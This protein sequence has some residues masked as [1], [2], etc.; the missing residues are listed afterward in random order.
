MDTPPRSHPTLNAIIQRSIPTSKGGTLEMH[1]RNDAGR[2]VL[3]RVPLQ[4][5]QRLYKAKVSPRCGM[6]GI[7]KTWLHLPEVCHGIVKPTGFT[8][9][10]TGN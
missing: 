7:G 3:S 8:P 1:S 4:P 2:Q 9:T 5:P 6:P 10:L